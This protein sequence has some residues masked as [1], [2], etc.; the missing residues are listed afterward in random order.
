MHILISIQEGEVCFLKFYFPTFK[1]FH[2]LKI[3]FNCCYFT[4]RLISDWFANAKVQLE[5]MC[6][7]WEVGQSCKIE[8]IFVEKNNVARY[9][10]YKTLSYFLFW[11]Y[12]RRYISKE[13]DESLILI[14]ALFCVII[15]YMYYIFLSCSK[16]STAKIL[17]KYHIF[18]KGIFK[19]KHTDG[20]RFI[21]LMA[22]DH[23]WILLSCVNQ[24]I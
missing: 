21:S 20:H 4:F 10:G 13:K 3:F 24:V 23:I 1:F 18:L 6:K 22:F 11:W 7:T 14:L 19:K 2:S 17:S 8:L 15:E 16:H 5:T 9:D 12:C